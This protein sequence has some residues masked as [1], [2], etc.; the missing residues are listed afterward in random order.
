MRA[1]RDRRG[2][3]LV[4]VLLATAILAVL[5]VL[6]VATLRVGVN[7]LEAGERRAAAHQEIRAVVE[8]VT[9]AL[10]AAYPYRGRRGTTPERVLLFEGEP[11]AVRFVTTTPPLLLDAPIAPFHA[12]VI[13]HAAD[14]QLQVVERLVPAEEPFPDEPHLVLSRSV[15]ALKLEYRDAQGVWQSTWDSRT[16]SALPAAVRVELTMQA[17]GRP[18]TTAT[19]VVP[20]LLGKDTL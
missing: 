18:S 2:L 5:V 10:S 19:F 13:R 14:S 8:L 9:E 17:G 6:L 15:S 4:E 3:T 7:A 1:L 12:V 16:A 20:I 11:D